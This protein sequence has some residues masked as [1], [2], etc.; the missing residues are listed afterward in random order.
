MNRSDIHFHILPGLDDGP[1]SV[2]ESVALARAAVADG[3]AAV[4]ATPHVRP[5]AV[6]DVTA[7]AEVTAE[8]RAA[9]SAAGI[10]LEVRRGAELGHT[11]VGRLG[12]AELEAIAQGP[13][14]ARWLLLEA[15]F[16]GFGDDFS[17]A[18]D[19]LRDRGFGV[20]VAHPERA[21]GALGG[22]RA[23]LSRELERSSVL[24]VNAWSLAGRH[25]GEARAAALR[26]VNQAPALVVASD[27]HGGW[28]QP[29]LTL[30]VECLTGAGR[31]AREA[32]RLVCSAP[33]RLLARGL[34]A[35]LPAAG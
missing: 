13:P 5:D 1:A 11:M 14:A 18:A 19:E 29:A 25:G 28:R 2:E 17:A 8:L 24:Q 6:T 34:R 9:L 3:S 21:A 35:P 15:P 27:A 20:V 12:Q 16:A 31:P 26:L 22:G 30:A 10:S 7:I 23:A 4:V 32:E 33:G